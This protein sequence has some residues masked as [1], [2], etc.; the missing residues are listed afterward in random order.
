MSDKIPVFILTY[1]GMDYLH[2]W[3]DPMKY[4]PKFQFYILDNGQQDIPDRFKD[5]V[6]YQTTRNI[7]CSGGYNLIMDIGFDHFNYEKII[8]AQEDGKFDDEHLERVFEGTA[9]NIMMGAYDNGF[10]M[11]IMGMTKFQRNAI[12]RMDENFVFAR[13]E[14]VDYLHRARMEN[15]HM[16]NLGF[17]PYGN[18]SM[19]RVHSVDEEMHSNQ[20]YLWGK[21]GGEPPV[22]NHP[23]NDDTQDIKI[24]HSQIEYEK[25]TEPSSNIRASQ[26]SEHFFLKYETV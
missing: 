6:V 15:I 12:G 13:C 23:F 14:D 25:Y 24:H 17:S 18:V 9:D 11:A 10:D 22:W 7:G 26:N 21:W 4:N 8:I 2:H 19:V 1:K 5:L 16:Q 20:L 3:F